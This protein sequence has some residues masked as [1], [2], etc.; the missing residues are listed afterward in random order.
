MARRG[1]DD[2]YTSYWFF[3]GGGFSW[4]LKVGYGYCIPTGYYC[5]Y[6]RYVRTVI[7]RQY[8]HTGITLYINNAV[9]LLGIDTRI[10]VLEV[11]RLTYIRNMNY[12]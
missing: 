7:T 3:F 6:T 4:E 5:I 12:L 8:S 2:V 11:L 10:T 9:I 1:G